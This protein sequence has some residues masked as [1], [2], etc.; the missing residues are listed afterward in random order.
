MV[1][2]EKFVNDLVQTL[3][4]SQ[5]MF[6]NSSDDKVLALELSGDFSGSLHI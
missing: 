2:T 5:V 6:P 3:A 4:G 1:S